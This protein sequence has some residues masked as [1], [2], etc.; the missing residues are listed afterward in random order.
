MAKFTKVIKT[1]VLDVEA[2]IRTTQH[3]LSS[4]VLKKPRL[5]MS[6]DTKRELR[7]ATKDPG[8]TFVGTPVRPCYFMGCEIDINDSLG[9]GEV[10][11]TVTL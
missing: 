8:W 4:L 9:F 5:V 7:E 11:F 1:E 2:L 3:H 10:L 6:S